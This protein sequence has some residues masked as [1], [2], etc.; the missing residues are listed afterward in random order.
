MV[1]SAKVQMPL[2][3]PAQGF[4]QYLR[5]TVVENLCGTD[6]NRWAAAE[7]EGERW[8]SCR[9]AAFPVEWTKK[10]KNKGSLSITGKT[11]IQL[12]VWLETP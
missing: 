3:L 10:L 1:N 8:S 9:H 7:E 12:P 6:S 2:W 11:T 4:T 5:D